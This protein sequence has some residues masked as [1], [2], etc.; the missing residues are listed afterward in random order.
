MPI[1]SPVTA[2][3]ILAIFGPVLLELSEQRL[4]SIVE[5]NLEWNMLN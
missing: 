3:L 2:G 4:V 5:I 1:Q